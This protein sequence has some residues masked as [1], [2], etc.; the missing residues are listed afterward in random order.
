MPESDNGV[1][2]AGSGCRLFDRKI[3]FFFVFQKMFCA[4]SALA[5]SAVGAA[6]QR[7]EAP[8][9]AA[10]RRE[11]PPQAAEQRAPH[12]VHF[13]VRNFQPITDFE[14]NLYGKSVMNRHFGLLTRSQKTVDQ[15]PCI[16]WLRCF[17]AAV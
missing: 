3:G 5:R 15:D 1:M 17:I 8:L 2:G 14:Q 9:G 13:C 16:S 11:A 7:R 4:R 10:Q 6:A 12:K